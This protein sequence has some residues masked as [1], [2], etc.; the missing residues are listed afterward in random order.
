[1]LSSDQE[2]RFITIDD[3]KEILKVIMEVHPGL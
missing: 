3:M 1:M 2:C